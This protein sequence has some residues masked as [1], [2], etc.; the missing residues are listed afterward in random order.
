MTARRDR[1]IDPVTLDYVDDGR[2]GFVE[3]DVLENQIVISFSVAFGSW[4]GDPT[5]GHRLGELARAVD[6]DLNRRRMADL[7]REALAWL[8]ADGSLESVECIVEQYDRGKVAFQVIAYRL[9]EESPVP[10]PSFLVPV[11]GSP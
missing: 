11:G 1:K 3:C 2:G 7:G 9:G 8:V 10:L 6:S 5:L 4:E